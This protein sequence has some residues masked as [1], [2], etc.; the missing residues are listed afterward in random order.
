M[1]GTT[2]TSIIKTC[3]ILCV[4]TELLLGDIVNTNAAYLSRQLA[5]LGI[6]VYRHT[7]V[8]DNPTRLSHALSSALSDADLVI[9]VGGL[10]PTYDDL[11]KETVSSYFGRTLSLHEHSLRRIEEYFAKTGRVMTENNKKQA[12]MPKGATVFDNHFGTAPALALCDE[13]S[14]KTVIM[15]PGPPVE[16]I[17]LFEE[18]IAPY[19][20]E[21]REG[22]IV[23]RNVYLFG[24]GESAMEEKIRNLLVESKNPTVA[25][26]CKAGE[27]RLRVAASAQDERTANSLCQEMIARLYASP[28]GEYVYG[29]DVDC[30]ERAVIRTLQE[31]NLT[32]AVAESCTGG[33]V[34]KRLTDISGA[35]SVFLGGCVTYTNQMKEALLGVVGKPC[36]T[37]ML[38]FPA[39]G[40]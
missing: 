39:T 37:K 9:T 36:V 23:S 4:G 28:I 6:N 21:R 10:G 40:L 35:S 18:Q 33:L 7:A 31:K 3:E 2:V 27:V 24:I 12:M 25:P 29:V 15:L 13:K 22:I 16:L 19:L 14:N 11:T 34:A 1:G 26:Y 30:L 8:G 32:L 20:A 17:P 38:E 5:A